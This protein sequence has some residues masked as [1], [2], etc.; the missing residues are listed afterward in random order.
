M[1]DGGLFACLDL[2]IDRALELEGLARDIIHMVQNA[3]READLIPDEHI[4]LGLR[5]QRDLR[6][7]VE[8][9]T[10]LI[11][12]EVLADELIV[13]EISRAFFTQT[14][15]IQDMPMGI[16]VKKVTGKLPSR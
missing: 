4:R 11:R 1:S 3:R 12:A 8:Q 9:H 15:E 10:G 6:E 5:V 14:V 2:H 13:G 7:A 16:T